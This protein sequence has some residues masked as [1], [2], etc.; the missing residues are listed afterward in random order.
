M[1]LITAIS[2]LAELEHVDICTNISVCNNI[3]EISTW[4][5]K[6]NERGRVVV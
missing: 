3:R 5:R 6:R 2:P 4:E 1:N